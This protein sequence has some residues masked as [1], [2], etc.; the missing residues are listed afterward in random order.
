MLLSPKVYLKMNAEEFNKEM[1]G[2]IN[3]LA[4][5]RARIK[6]EYPNCSFSIRQVEPGLFVVSIKGTD[7]ELRKVVYVRDG[8]DS[9]ET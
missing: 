6:S 2:M 7:G 8:K 4:K 5:V 3:K 1:S 9:P